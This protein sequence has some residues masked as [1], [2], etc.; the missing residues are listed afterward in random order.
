GSASFDDARQHYEAGKAAAPGDV[1]L[2]Y[3]MA[4]VA[5][6]NHNSKDAGGF[7][8][9]ALAG[10]KTVLPIRRTQIWLGV[11]QGGKDVAAHFWQ[12]IQILATADATQ[13]DV[14]ETAKWLGSLIGFL[15]GP[16]QSQL[17]AADRTKLMD[18]I[19]TLK[20]PLADEVKAGIKEVGD[21]YN[22]FQRQLT[23]AQ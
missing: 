19:D 1:R 17:S 20:G 6:H 8:T 2:P 23:Q 5:L 14:Q 12:L 3:A 4:L 10:G 16:G 11:S 22:Q 7:L 21:Q 9:E 13:A 15:N 18:E